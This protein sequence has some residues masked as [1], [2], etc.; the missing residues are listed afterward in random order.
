LA[1]HGHASISFNKSAS[2]DDLQHGGAESIAL[3]RS[4]FALAVNLTPKVVS[5]YEN[6]RY[7]FCAGKA[8]GGEVSVKDTYVGTTVKGELSYDGPVSTTF[9]N[10]AT[11]IF[12][13]VACKYVFEV[14]YA[15]RAAFTGDDALR[16][17]TTVSGSAVGLRYGIPASLQLHGVDYPDAGGAACQD[18]IQTGNACFSFTG[19]WSQEFTTL[20]KCNSL[21]PQGGCATDDKPAGGAIFSWSLSPVYAK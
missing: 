1:F 19:G 2:G 16:P 21:T 8:T 15:V 11:L 10:A 13:R 4:A 6:G 7:V 9:P 20:F 14:G 18:P 12:D 17:Y 3:K 5:K